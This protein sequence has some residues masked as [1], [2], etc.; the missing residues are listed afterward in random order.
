MKQSARRPN[1]QGSVIGFGC[2]VI[3]VDV[4]KNLFRGEGRKLVAEGQIIHA[5]SEPD[6][7][8]SRGLLGL[9]PQ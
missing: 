5:G 3:Q 8:A 2:L 6:V 1:F 7:H 9:R 4:E